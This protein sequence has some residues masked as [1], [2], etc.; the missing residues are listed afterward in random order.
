MQLHDTTDGEGFDMVGTNPYR[1][2]ITGAFESRKVVTG[3]L[4]YQMAAALL[5]EQ[6]HERNLRTIKRMGHTQV[7]SSL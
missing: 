6:D 2:Y 5:N 1:R 7:K 3:S 4:A